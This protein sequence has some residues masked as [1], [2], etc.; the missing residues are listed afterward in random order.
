MGVRACL[1]INPPTAK[2]IEPL[3][4]ITRG[5]YYRTHLLVRGTVCINKG[6]KAISRRSDHIGRKIRRMGKAFKVSQ[7]VSG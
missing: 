6:N 4:H 2:S 7:I 5:T 1:V 3:Q